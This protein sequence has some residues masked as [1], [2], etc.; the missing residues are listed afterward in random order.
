MAATSIVLGTPRESRTDFRTPQKEVSGFRRG[1]G[2]KDLGGKV[3]AL[4][5]APDWSL[6]RFHGGAAQRRDFRGGYQPH[7]CLARSQGS[8]PNVL[9]VTVQQDC[10]RYAFA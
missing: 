2:T 1:I 4:R 6:P 7:R 9:L 10:I 5:L 3:Q 8:H